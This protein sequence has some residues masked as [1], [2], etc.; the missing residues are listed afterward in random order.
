VIDSTA[1]LQQLLQCETTAATA[2]KVNE[3]E[4]RSVAD[5]IGWSSAQ[6]HSDDS[7]SDGIKEVT[8]SYWLYLHLQYHL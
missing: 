2:L 5:T 3:S 8:Q 6:Q 7:N 1:G 4:L